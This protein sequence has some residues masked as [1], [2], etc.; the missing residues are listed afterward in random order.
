M[1]WVLGIKRC[2]SSLWEAQQRL[3]LFL[4]TGGVGSPLKPHPVLVVPEGER[5]T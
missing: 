4:I 5:K 3:Q 1:N 2:C